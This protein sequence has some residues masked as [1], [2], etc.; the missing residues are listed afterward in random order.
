M[1]SIQDILKSITTDPI[2][3][4]IPKNIVFA[5]DESGSTGATFSPG[6]T[7]LEKEISIMY[8]YILKYPNNNYKLFSFETGCVEHPIHIMKE[9]GLVDLPNLYPKG[10]TNTHLPLLKINQLQGKTDLVILLTDGET[11]SSEI[12][13]KTEINKFMEKKIKFEII[14]VSAKNINMDTISHAEENRIPGMDLINYLSNSVDKLTIYNQYHK[15]TPY[16]GATSSTVNKNCMVFMD[17]KIV[18]HVHDYLHKLLAKLDEAKGNI[19]WGASDLNFKKIIVQI[20]KLLTIYMVTFPIK[21][22][23]EDSLTKTSKYDSAEHFL[24]D[25]IITK[26]HDICNISGMTPERIYDMLNYGFVCTKN[27]KPFQYTNFEQHVKERAVKQNEFKNAINTLKI[28]GTTLNSDKTISMPTN[29]VCIINNKCIPLTQNLGTYPNSKDQF[30]NVYFG[31]DEIDGQATRIA[32]RELCSSLGYRNSRG[33]EPAF[34]VL[35]EMALMFIKGVE[36]NSEHMNELRKLAIIQTSME[37]MISKDKYDGIGL[38]KQWQTGRTLA[39]N[40]VNPTQFHSSLYQEIKINPLKLEEPIWWALMMTMLGLFEEQRHNYNTAL[41]VKGISNLDEFLIWLKE[42]Y[43]DKVQGHINLYIMN[44]L[45]TSVFTLEHFNPTD[46]VYKLKKH[47]QCN[48]GTHYSRREIED[49]V[50]TSGCVWC[51]HHPTWDNFETVNNTNP[52]KYAEHISRIMSGSSKLC[53]PIDSVVTNQS[54]IDTFS[55]G[56]IKK[57]IINMIGITGAGKSTCSA[58]IKNIITDNGGSCLIVNSDN[59]SKKGI[60]GKQQKSG[61]NKELR[62]FDRAPSNYKVIVVDICNENGPSSNCFGFDTSS[63][64]TFNFYPNLDKTKFDDYQCWCLNNVLMRTACTEEDNYWLNPESAG[65]ATCIRVHN[66]KMSGIEKLLG[67]V[68]KLTFFESGSKITIMDQLRI[69]AEMYSKYLLTK[70]QDVIIGDFI[71]SIGIPL[72]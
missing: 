56:N 66:I 42:T 16:E 62:D 12:Q 31:C 30:G 2:E 63:Y 65:I 64:T 54:I 60:T 7:V 51:R 69:G 32:F 47:G 5:S 15:D 23:I 70:N 61:I 67:V 25:L 19:N 37:T 6:M 39:I 57:V 50:L 38:Y 20:G 18:G 44:S 26:M 4:T 27:E 11:N 33:P 22:F 55:K 9:E 68:R 21:H 43:K 34:Y 28:Q 72:L 71:K 48:T 14:A 53:V 58:K 8:E 13:L 10:G 36:I 1:Q 24:V 45:P 29:G 3:N 17:F 59:W 40:Y 52:T 35:N 49:Y 41:A 46:E